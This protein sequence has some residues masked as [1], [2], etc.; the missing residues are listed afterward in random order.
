MESAK[1]TTGFRLSSQVR[2]APVVWRWDPRVHLRNLGYNLPTGTR[3][4]ARL[5]EDPV[6]REY[7]AQLAAIDRQ[8][9]AAVNQRIHLV[10]QVKAHKTTQGRSFY[11]PA[12]EDRVLAN[13]AQANPGPLSEAGL[14]ALFGLILDWAKREADR[15]G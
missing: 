4:V 9:L 8:I 15:P 5:N 13:L 10:K 3:E 7:R 6:M 2:R 12:Q 1:E 11:D 14:R